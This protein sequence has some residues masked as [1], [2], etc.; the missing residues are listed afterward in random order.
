M[1]TKQLILTE[2]IAGLGAEADVVT[3]KAGYARNFLLPRGMAYEVT[4]AALRRINL[5]KAKRAQREAE[6]LSTAEEL[7]RRIK[8][9]TL[10]FKLESGTTGK[11]FGSVTAQDIANRL[12]AELKGPLI[13]RHK[14]VLD[15][16]IKE[17][18]EFTIPVKIH[19]DV[20]CELKVVVSTVELES[21]TDSPTNSAEESRP[22]S[23]KRK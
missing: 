18:G 7:A 20:P 3:V 17:N 6:E 10:D 16:P 23:R 21:K 9:L 2:K 15:R 1:A 4:P 5:L 11:A 14:L 8:K 13:D 12:E 19:P 22:T